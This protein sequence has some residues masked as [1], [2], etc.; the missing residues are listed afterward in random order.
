MSEEIKDDT[1]LSIPLSEMI[2]TLRSELQQSMKEAENAPLQF[3]LE[4]V[5]LEL[6]VRLT[7]ETEGKGGLQFWVISAGG[8]HKVEQ[9]DIHTFKLK[10]QP[11]LAG[12]PGQDVL[13]ADVT[14]H[15]PQ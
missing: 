15:K 5:E 2:R 6:K 3:K 7:K 9:Q 10:L 1:A 12:S 11:T 8:K 13:V 4:S 14:P